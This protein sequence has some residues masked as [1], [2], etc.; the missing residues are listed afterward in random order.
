LRTGISSRAEPAVEFIEEL[1]PIEL[2]F[3]NQGITSVPELT[4]PC[5]H[6]GAEIRSDA[7]FCRHCGSS[8]SDGWQ[9]DDDYGTDMDDFDYDQFVEDNF[10]SS[11]TTTQ[12]RP[13]WR[14]VAVLLLVLFLLGYL[15]L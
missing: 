3:K 4:V 2:L 6:C 11:V 8:D 13:L 1:F 10:S 12:T 7:K 15:L 14:L 9:D 5:P